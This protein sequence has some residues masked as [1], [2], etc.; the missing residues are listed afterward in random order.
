MDAG[1]VLGIALAALFIV[2]AGFRAYRGDYKRDMRFKAPPE[3]AGTG[4]TD[5]GS[6]QSF[7]KKDLKERIIPES[8]EASGNQKEQT[9]ARELHHTK[10]DLLLK[11]LENVK[12]KEGLREV[13]LKEIN[14]LS[15]QMEEIKK[16]LEGIETKY[17]L[18]ESDVRMSYAFSRIDWLIKS[19]PRLRYDPDTSSLRGEI[20]KINHKINNLSGG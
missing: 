1:F 4:I 16:G 7:G 8:G 15:S 11:L 13:S 14:S 18:R 9:H 3:Y 5:T 2:L 6:A 10:A 12:K 17:D 19:Y 20:R